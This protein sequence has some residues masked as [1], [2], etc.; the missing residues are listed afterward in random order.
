MEK[1]IETIRVTRNNFQQL[2]ESLSINDL[3]KIPEGFSNNIIWN[4]GHCIVSQQILCY[5]LSG[6]PLKIEGS[7]ISK[8]SKGSK[9]EKFL[10][11]NELEFLK[12]QDVKLIKELSEDFENNLFE[13]FMPYKTGFQIE[14]TNIADVLKYICMHEGLHL[15]YSMAL[16]RAIRKTSE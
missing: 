11:E 2:M 5:K 10:D 13:N 9:P 16:K 14:L 12:D 1:S 7:N 6:L 4:F 3:N 15:G 8:Y